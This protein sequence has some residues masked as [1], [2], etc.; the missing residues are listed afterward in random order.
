MTSS[1]RTP[2]RSRA[3][4]R[5]PSTQRGHGPASAVPRCWRV[6]ARSDVLRTTVQQDKFVSSHF[7]RR[8]WPAYQ[9][10][11]T[12]AQP[13]WALSA[14][15]SPHRAALQHPRLAALRRGGVPRCAFARLLMAMSTTRRCSCAAAT[16]CRLLQPPPLLRCHRLL[17]RSPRAAAKPSRCPTRHTP[18]CRYETRAVAAPRASRATAAR[19]VSPSHATLTLGPA[20]A[21]LQPFDWRGAE[22]AGLRIAEVNVGSG[23]V[24]ENG[25]LLTVRP[26][27][28]VAARMF[29]RARVLMRRYGAAQVQYD[30]KYRG[31]VAVSSREGRLLGTNSAAAGISATA[32]ALTF[33]T[34]RAQ[35]ATARWQSR[36]SSSTASCPRSSPSRASAK[37][38]LA[39][40]SSC[41]RL[42]QAAPTPACSLSRTSRP[43]AP[44]RV[45][46]C[47]RW[48]VSWPSKVRHTAPA[49]GF[50]STLNAHP[51]RR[52]CGE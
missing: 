41:A 15:L 37:P 34:A 6:R 29:A 36:S 51:P 16:R 4:P 19:L 39:S 18:R 14:Q 50:S 26:G 3:A 7:S 33:P 25:A 24:V 21:P 27:A 43:A 12:P 52:R 32:R 2:L 30:C 47:A 9:R 40:A 11:S 17:P 31:I 1:R 23:K 10:C 44:P 5:P 45:R 35:G 48:T 38:S 20:A 49:R 13:R 42:S 46:A 22:H 28:S 8:S